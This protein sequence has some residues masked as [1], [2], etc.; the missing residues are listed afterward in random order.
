MCSG[1]FWCCYLGS[2]MCS[3]FVWMLLVMFYSDFSVMLW[4][5]SVYLCVSL[6]L[7]VLNVVDM[8]IVWICILLLCVKC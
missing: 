4:L 1:V 5:C 7:L 2:S 3:W 8:G 6:L